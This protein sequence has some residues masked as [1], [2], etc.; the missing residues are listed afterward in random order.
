[1]KFF[2]C[3][4]VFF[5]TVVLLS[6]SLT[7]LRSYGLA[8]TLVLMST[9]LLFSQIN[10]TIN[11]NGYNYIMHPNGKVASE[12]M[13]RDGKPD[14]Y[15][16]SYHTTGIKSSEGN[17]VNFLRDSIWVFYTQTGDT[18]EIIRYHL[19]KKSGFHYIFETIVERNQ[20][21]KHY[22]KSKEMFLDDR[23]EGLSYYY[24]PSGNLR[25][26][27]FYR[28]GKRQGTYLDGNI[29]K[30]YDEEGTVITLYEFHN[31]YYISR[32]FINRVNANGERTGVWKTFYPNGNLKEE[33]VYKNG[34][35]DGVST[36]FSE[37]GN[38]IV[39]NQRVYREGRLIED[40]IQMTAE[41]M[42]LNTFYEDGTTLKRKGWYLDSIPTGFHF[43]YDR[44]GK[45]ERSIR[46]SEKATGLPTGEGPID[47]ND[48]R[49]GEWKLYF[50]TGELRARGRFV[51]DR[52]HGEWIYF[53]KDGKREQV[54][55][56]N[57]SLPDGEWTWFYP[58]GNVR[59]VDMMSRNV[60][61]GLS[62]QYSDSATIIAKGE[63]LDGEREGFWIENIG[64]TREEGHY[65]MGNKQD[66]WKT[67]HK[68]GQLYHTGNFTQGSPDGRHLFY[69][70]DGTLKEEQ[71]YV[72]GRRVKNWKKYNENGT[73]FLT[74]TYN[75]DNEIRINGIR[76]D[77]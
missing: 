46:Y 20:L 35:L 64:D 71:H 61:S 13:M 1:M 18:S 10:T 41:P 32:E 16:K 38:N 66:V 15:W 60:L 27:I 29:S 45:P 34:V 33:E 52:Q 54:G 59:R 28:N 53:F 36:V 56:L 25:Q 8:L 70:P 40:A 55:N 31:D 42:F 65:I 58:S 44:E 74:I 17:R 49:V 47:E 5:R 48:R 4:I 76:I 2:I 69:Y 50:E 9:Q 68:D 37:R 30:E 72:M 21:S 11:P 24:Y 77:R 51:N 19:G 57:N 22:L 3:N 67:F 62:I 43:F 73:L 7:V 63:Y 12:G 39:I 14:G 6:Y 26:T 23:R 75:N